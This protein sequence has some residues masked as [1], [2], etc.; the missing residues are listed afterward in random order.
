MPPPVL[1]IEATQ[2]ASSTLTRKPTAHLSRATLTHPLQT[3]DVRS[4]S[5]GSRL[6]LEKVYAPLAL[7]M[8]LS[9]HYALSQAIHRHERTT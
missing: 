1:G 5:P 2:A 7:T 3:R 9:G 6:P 4:K 8:D